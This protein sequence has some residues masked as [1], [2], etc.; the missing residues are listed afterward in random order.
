[1]RRVAAIDAIVTE[2]AAWGPSERRIHVT[3]RRFIQTL[4][5]LVNAGHGGVTALEMSSWA[6]RLGHYVFILR[7]KYGLVIETQ[8][9]PHDGGE[10]A[11]YHLV[12]DVRIVVDA[13]QTAA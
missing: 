11:R 9:E 10:Q 8:M 2:P 7:R 4:I 12:S 5:A 13:D 1:M 6:L 3:G